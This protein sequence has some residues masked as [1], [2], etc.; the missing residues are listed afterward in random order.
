[1][2]FSDQVVIGDAFR[3]RLRFT[4]LHFSTARLYD[5][6]AALRPEHELLHLVL[7]GRDGVIGRAEPGDGLSL[8]VDD[9]LG[10]VPLDGAEDRG[11]K[12]IKLFV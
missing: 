12:S 4:G 10:E 7:H 8:L 11:V 9:K 3:V 2:P 6:Y 1:M 5:V